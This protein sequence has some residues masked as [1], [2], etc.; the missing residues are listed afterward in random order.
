MPLDK[1]A[2]KALLAKIAP[3][4]EDGSMAVGTEVKHAGRRWLIGSIEKTR[5]ED[6]E[7]D[8][9]VVVLGIS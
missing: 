7:P 3:G 5:T 9:N 8:F 4:I 6:G 1:K 2:R